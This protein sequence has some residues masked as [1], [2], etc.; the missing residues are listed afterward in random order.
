M[1]KT[2]TRRHYID[3]GHSWIRVPMKE[4][5]KLGI[6]NSITEY[7]HMLGD[8]AYLECDQDATVYTE[9][10]KAAGIALKLVDLTRTRSAKLRN[11]PQYS[12][13]AFEG[14]ESEI[15]QPRRQARSKVQPSG[16]DAKPKAPVKK[17]VPKTQKTP[18]A[19]T[20]GDKSYLETGARFTS[21]KLKKA[22]IAEGDR[23]SIN[24]DGER[25]TA[26]VLTILSEQIVCLMEDTE[27]VAFFF[28]KGLVIDKVES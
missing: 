4:I 17:R 21:K 20:S 13:S 23:V 24:D 12:Q 16:G 7:S 15:K 6:Q 1:S 8:F 5:A 26:K 18:A 19:V 22:K 27:C 14:V 9:A 25:R 3:P 11:Y 28:Q 2:A 10:M